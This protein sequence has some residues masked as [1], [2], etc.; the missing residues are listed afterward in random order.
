MHRTYDGIVFSERDFRL[1]KSETIKVTFVPC[2]C[3][4]NMIIVTRARGLSGHTKGMIQQQFIGGVKQTLMPPM[5][6]HLA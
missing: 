6:V 2:S 1:G 3:P 4:C 5:Y